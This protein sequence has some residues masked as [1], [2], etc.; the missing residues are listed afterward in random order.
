MNHN[1]SRDPEA[2]RRE[3]RG[4]LECRSS[5]KHVEYLREKIEA[6]QSVKTVSGSKAAKQ[7]GKG[8]PEDQKQGGVYLLYCNYSRDPEAVSPG[9]THHRGLILWNWKRASVYCCFVTT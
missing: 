3:D 8:V 6:F 5:I 9:D 7:A 2:A 1:Y 4:I